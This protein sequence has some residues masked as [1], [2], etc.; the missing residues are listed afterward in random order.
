MNIKLNLSIFTGLILFFIISLTSCGDI[1][2]DLRIN[3]DGS[4]TLETSL[5]I[6]ELLS[7]AKGFEDIGSDLDTFSDDMVLPDTA[8]SEPAPPKDAMTLLIEKVTDPNYAR[9]FDTTMSFLSIMPDS[10]KEKETRLDL[11]EKM[12]VKMKSP[13]NSGNLTF[14][15]LMKFDNTKQLQELID[16]MESFN[17][18]S[19][20]MSGASPVSMDS[21]TFLSFDADMNAGWIRLD[22]VF[23]KGF[24]EQMGMSPDS[25]MSGEDLGMLEMM[26]GNSKIKSV[27]HVPGEVTSC[28]NADAILT[29]DNRVILEYPMMD[30]IRKGRIDG[31]TVYFKP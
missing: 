15:V 9:D 25:A 19:N 10:V 16:Y 18:N 31:Y 2:Q 20:M 12:F 21:E 24:A 22:T 5:D 6:G 28:S 4:G 27:I 8:I 3:K 11:I 29:K 17:Q 26:F 13:A 23:Y 7:M 1:Q 30:V 14:G